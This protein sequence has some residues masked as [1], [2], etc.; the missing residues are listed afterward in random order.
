MTKKT[1]YC[2]KCATRHV[3]PTGKKCQ[4]D[5]VGNGGLTEIG[6]VPNG[7]NLHSLSRTGQKAVDADHVTPEVR[8]ESTEGSVQD[9]VLLFI[10]SS[11]SWNI[12]ILKIV[13]IYKRVTVLYCIIIS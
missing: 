4:R 7:L 10:T 1:I 5:S 13:C 9:M 3:A 8:L 11:K 2:Q 6:V 12:Y